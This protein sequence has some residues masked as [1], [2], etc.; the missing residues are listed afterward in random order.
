MN[1][2]PTA[3]VHPGARLAEDVTVGPY[4]I[5]EDNVTIGKG[6]KIGA[7]AV[8]KPFVDIGEYNEIYQFT[9]IGEVPQD[10]KF[11]GEETKLIIGDRNK[12][13][14]FAT[15]NRGTVGGGGVTRIGNDCFILSYAHIAHDCI[16][17]DNVLIVN[18][19]QMGGHVHI[20]YHAVVG[21]LAALHQFIRI[22]AHSMIGG[23]S[24]VSQDVP[25][26]TNVA[27]NH[28]ILHGLNLVG[29]KRR[30]FS[31]E[32]VAAIKKAYQIIFRSGLTFKDAKGKVLAEVAMTPEVDLMLDFI[33][34]S[35]R[36]VI[37]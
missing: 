26:F 31:S 4:A 37:R 29:M 5:I 12:I 32:S 27:G 3:I 19:V 20:G 16:I 25:P 14:E 18:C 34:Q 11:G 1:I 24:A 8:I 23:G 10:Y 30:G 15:L 17:E 21:G 6:T 9:S 36:G 35:K 13:R 2:H 28:A 22:G 7:H 33:E